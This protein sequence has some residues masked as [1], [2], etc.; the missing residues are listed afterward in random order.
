[1]PADPRPRVHW[2]VGGLPK[3]DELDECA[4]GFPNVAAAYTI[5]EAGPHFADILAPFMH[6]EPCEMLS[7]AVQRAMAAAR[8][9]DVILLSP[10]C[11]S[12]DQF[13]DYEARG[14][15]FRHLVAELT[16]AEVSEQEPAA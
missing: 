3:S 10:A 11:A 16:G 1:Y 9:G 6:V 2:I 13:K 7:E 5:G 14:D 12:F 15:C 8:P 4:P